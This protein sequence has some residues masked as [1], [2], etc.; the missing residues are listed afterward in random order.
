MLNDSATY[1]D[2]RASSFFSSSSS[3]RAIATVLHRVELRYRSFC[4]CFLGCVLPL[5]L[6]PS[7]SESS[8]RTERTPQESREMRAIVPRYRCSQRQTNQTTTTTATAATVTASGRVG[9][10]NRSLPRIPARQRAP[11]G[12]QTSS[13]MTETGGGVVWDSRP[14]RKNAKKR[15][16]SRPAISRKTP[17]FYPRWPWCTVISCYNN[18]MSGNSQIGTEYYVV[19]IPAGP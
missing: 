16:R 12:T 8:G 4:F 9:V 3:G 2:A 10:N 19:R 5:S 14:R 7:R 17:E 6:A 18:I 13:I 11:P 15:F 1:R